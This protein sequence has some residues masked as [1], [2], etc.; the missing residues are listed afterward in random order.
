MK[1]KIEIAFVDEDT[2][3]AYFSQAYVEFLYSEIELYKSRIDK[4]IE[5]IKQHCEI[6]RFEDEG[7]DMIGKVEGIPLLNIL[8]GEEN[9]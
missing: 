6:V 3:E 8:Q 4:A 2:E 7:V 1:D 9:E 5:Y